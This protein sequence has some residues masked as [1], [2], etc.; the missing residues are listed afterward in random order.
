MSRTALLP[1]NRTFGTRTDAW[2]TTDSLLNRFNLNLQDAQ[3]TVQALLPTVANQLQAELDVEDRTTQLGEIAKS[4]KLARLKEVER[5]KRDKELQ[6]EQERARRREEEKG[7]ALQEP[8]STENSRMVEAEDEKEQATNSE[9]QL[10]TNG[11]ESTDSSLDTK[12][13]TT[14]KISLNPDAPAFQPRFA[15]PPAQPSSIEEDFPKL[16]G[17]CS[18][19]GSDPERGADINGHALQNGKDE[20]TDHKEPDGSGLGRSWAEIVKTDQAIESVGNG[21]A[22]LIEAKEREG[23]DPI[24]SQEG[25]NVPTKE[26]GVSFVRM[27]RLPHSSDPFAFRQSGKETPRAQSREASTEPQQVAQTDDV[28]VPQLPSKSKIQLWNEI[29]ILCASRMRFGSRTRADELTLDSVVSLHPDFDI[30]LR[31]ITAHAA[32]SRSTRPPRSGSLRQ[33][34]HRLPSPQIPVSDRPCNFLDSG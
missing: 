4:E 16:N 7:S 17:H 3:F 15:P 23:D 34:A 2:S 13:T 9:P 6:D 32:D 25:E 19:S 20:A 27:S 29:K 11:L 10:Q 24:L 21:Q 8:E 26:N 22:E 12:S 30:D 14:S 5:V 18:D 28:A 31:P 1:H 33:I